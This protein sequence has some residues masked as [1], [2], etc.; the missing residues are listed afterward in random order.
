M[1]KNF[2]PDDWVILAGTWGIDADEDP[3]VSKTGGSSLKFLGNATDTAIRSAQFIPIEG[4][5]EYLGEFESQA[6]LTTAGF[7]YN[8]RVYW[9]DENK[10]AASTVY[11]SIR[12]SLVA[13]AVDTWEI[14]STIVTAPT[15]ARYAK[16]YSAK[17]AQAFTVNIDRFKFIRAIPTWQIYRN[18]AYN[19]PS[20][21][22]TTLPYD[23]NLDL[24][25]ATVSSGVVTIVTPGLYVITSRMQL[26][27][28]LTT[29]YCYTIIVKNQATTPVTIATGTE[30]RNYSAGTLS[31]GSNATAVARLAAG[32]TVEVQAYQS[33]PAV[34]SVISNVNLTYFHGALVEQ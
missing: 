14:A 19:L 25:D 33:G 8:A 15:D 32:D 3:T 2:P 6:N 9:Y 28:L 24:V 30:G 12:G 23:S 20:T 11:S 17:A 5:K 18:A 21:T 13:G 1:S 34:R 4:G 7:L 31:Q 22:V 27:A 10:D 16:L 29:E 26:T